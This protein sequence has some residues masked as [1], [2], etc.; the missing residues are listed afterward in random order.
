MDDS[1]LR[2]FKIK[3]DS[4]EQPSSLASVEGGFLDSTTSHTSP[5]KVV[6]R[7]QFRGSFFTSSSTHYQSKEIV[8]FSEQ[9]L[10]PHS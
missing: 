9:L 10:P 4:N 6:I 8:S 5:S 3:Q 7:R 1:L 2:D